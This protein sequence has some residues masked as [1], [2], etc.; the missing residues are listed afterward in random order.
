MKLN[1]LPTY[2]SKGKQAATAWIFSILLAL[3]SVV[4]A[5]AM[6]LYSK[7][8]KD[9]AVQLVAERQPEYEKVKALAAKADEIIAQGRPIMVNTKLAET[10]QAHN[11]KYPDL[12]D[13]VLNFVPSWFRVRS[14]QA[15]PAGPGQSTV[16]ISGYLQTQ[17]QYADLMLALTRIP[18]VASVS[19]G[20]YAIVAPRVPKL[21][22][23]DQLGRPLRPGEGPVPTD[24]HE[25][26]TYYISQ[27]SVSGFENVSNFG[28][29][30]NEAEKGGMPGWSLVTVALSLPTD[31]MVPDP[32]GTLGGIAA[33][34]GAPSFQA[35]AGGTTPAGNPGAPGA[36]SGPGGPGR[37][38]PGA[39]GAPSGPGQVGRGG[40][41]PDAR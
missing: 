35:P 36:P 38:N 12:Y 13:Q 22:E 7:G 17:Q 2:V 29:G 39:P 19:R 8:L 21:T 27:G 18:G 20:G 30:D 34:T 9:R 5:V 1:L 14:I 24:P 28:T 31:L 26:L 37:G 25:R 32:R 6:I 3:L 40:A 16:Q 15:T 23:V 41:D 11:T 4:A 10:M 33:L